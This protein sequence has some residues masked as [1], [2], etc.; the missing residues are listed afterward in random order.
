MLILN[1]E[2]VSKVLDMPRCLA[3]LDSVFQEM[4]TG[5]AVSMGRIDVYVP[6]GEQQAPFY[7]WAVMAGSWPSC[8]K[9]L[10]DGWHCRQRTSPTR[11]WCRPWHL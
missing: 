10:C 3:S 8:E 2:D 6:S 7:R 11:N 4:A 1:N 5:D 9:R